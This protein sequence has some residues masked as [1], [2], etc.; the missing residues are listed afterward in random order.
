ANSQIAALKVLTVDGYAY[1]GW[2]VNG[3]QINASIEPLFLTTMPA[4][5]AN[6]D[7]LTPFTGNTATVQPACSN[8]ILTVPATV[9]R[10]EIFEVSLTADPPPQSADIPVI[11]HLIGQKNQN[12][13]ERGEVQMYDFGYDIDGDGDIDPGQMASFFNPSASGTTAINVVYNLYQPSETIKIQATIGRYTFESLP[14]EVTYQIRKYTTEQ[15]YI[16]TNDFDENADPLKTIQYWVDYWDDWNY[17]EGSEPYTFKMNGD[18]IVDKLTYDLA[19]S[20]CFKESH[21][22]FTNLMQVKDYTIPSFSSE[23]DV[24]WSA[25]P[26]EDG[27]Y[28]LGEGHP[29]MQYTGVT[30]ASEAQSLKW[31]IRWLY[32]KKSDALEYKQETNEVYNLTWYNWTKTLEEYNGEEEKVQYAKDVMAL[33]LSGKNPHE[34][35]PEY[36]WP[37]MT[38]GKARE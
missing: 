6:G 21:M 10:D 8:V 4:L 2:I 24:N 1:T 32:A 12:L 34:G 38:N 15:G 13:P 29:K 25:E 20:V 22:A 9:K 14:I 33:Y 30:N 27:G 19:K 31:G 16:H 17:P 18:V 37:I 26:Q 5:A 11:W 28:K 23:R 3:A 7:W 36:M 35:N